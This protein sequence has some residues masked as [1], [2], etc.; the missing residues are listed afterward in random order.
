[1]LRSQS[2]NHEI[3]LFMLMKKIIVSKVIVVFWLVNTSSN[4]K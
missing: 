2:F 1:M 4:N 3:F